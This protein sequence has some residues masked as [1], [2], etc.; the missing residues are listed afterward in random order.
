M[1]WSSSFQCSISPPLPRK[2][3]SQIKSSSGVDSWRSFHAAL[4]GFS[5]RAATFALESLRL[6]LENVNE[7]CSLFPSSI[8]LFLESLLIVSSW[9]AS[10]RLSH[11]ISAGWE[12]SI[13]S[14]SVQCTSIALQ[15]LST[16]LLSPLLCPTSCLFVSAL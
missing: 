13:V 11:M 8:L 10:F 16:C 4:S 6:A 7:S 2:S 5:V 14:P 15:F 9:P 3:T 12:S 1:L